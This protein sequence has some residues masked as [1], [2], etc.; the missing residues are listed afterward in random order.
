MCDPRSVLEDGILQGNGVNIAAFE[1]I[2]PQN[3]D[4]WVRTIAGIPG[5]SDVIS[6]LRRRARPLTYS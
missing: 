1:S 6:E 2:R 4:R 3:A 5:A